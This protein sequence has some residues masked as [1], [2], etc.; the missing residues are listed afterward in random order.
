MI[1]TSLAAL[2][3]GQ[4]MTDEVRL[5]RYPDIHGDQYVFTYASDLW[6][7]QVDGGPARRLTSHPGLERNAKFSPDGQW[8]AFT[9]QYD[10][11]NDI[12]VIPTTGG[13][14]RRLTFEAQSENLRGWTPDGKK[15]AYTSIDGNHTNRMQRLWFVDFEGGMPERT[16]VQEAADLTFNADGSKMA[17]TRVA[18]HQYNW[19]RYRGGTQG[20]I[21]FW[22]FQAKSYTEIPTG[23]EQSYFPMW[24]GDT[25]YYISDRAQG[26]LNLWAY[27]TGPRRQRQLTRFTEGDIR[28]PATDGKKVIFERNLRLH[29]YD[30]ASGAIAT[31]EP[32]VT[33]D[34][35]GMRPRY[36][37][38]ANAVDS[39]ALSPSGARVVAEARGELF[40]VPATRGTT[41]NLTE[42]PGARERLAEW[43][44]DG[45]FV[46]YLSDASGEYKITR[47][48]Q[49]GGDA[50]VV[51]TPAEHRIAGF[52]LPLKGDKIAYNTN[53]FGLYVLDR[54]TGQSSLVHQDA[55]GMASYEW[56]PDGKWI[57]YMATQ[58]NLMSRV[59]LYDV[60]NKRS[61]AV[62]DGFYS[63]NSVSFDQSGKYLYLISSRTFGAT[64]SPMEGVTLLQQNMQRLYVITLDKSLGDPLLE[65]EDE[66]PVKT[67]GGEQGGPQGGGQQGSGD[68]KID[69]E[70]IG[71]RI[72]PLPLPAGNYP[73]VIGVNNGALYWANGTLSLF[74]MNTKRP[75]PVMAGVS[76]LSTNPARTKM[77]YSAGALQGIA[78]I[79]PGLEAGVGRVSFN[80]MGM[81][82]DPAAEFRQMYWD[83]WRFQRDHFYDPGMMGV[84][85]K[86]VG[87][88]WA[89]LL[90]NVGD[91]SDLDYMFG[92]LIGELGT[93]H[94]YVSPGPTGADPMAPPAGYLG[95]DYATVGNAVTFKKIYR[96]EEQ[97]PSVRGPL[98]RLG[99]EVNDGEYL[100]AIDG[101]PVTAKTGVSPHLIG[102]AN[103][104]VTL[105]VNSRN[106][107]VGAREVVVVPAT[108][109][110]N[111]RYQ[112]WVDERRA[113]VDKL[114]GGKVGYIHVP[115]TSVPGI[116]GF[117]KGF[118][119]QM[120]KEAWLVDERYNGGGSIPTFFIEAL[121]REF[122]NMIR[123]RHGEDVGLPVA[124]N[125]PKA[126]L[127][128][129]HAGSG[130]DLFPYLFKKAGL[131]PLIGT[132][133]WGG[134]VGISGGLQ[135]VA[136]GSVTSP[137]FGIYDPQTGQWIAENTGVDPDIEIDDDPA[138]AATGKDVQ[139][140]RGVRY[141]MEQL[142][143]GRTGIKSPATFP[144]L[145]G[146]R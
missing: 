125:G 101:K 83:V 93:G 11:G 114:S 109:E 18:S 82:T 146:G 47:K 64:G 51:A 90:G 21:A 72:V 88:K 66:E 53:E 56:S 127:I 79:R 27:E 105:T 68:I 145:D 87:D 38:L 122:T 12:Y 41:R 103:K 117:V 124:L 77:I 2:A 9:G 110:V 128:N 133:T 45:Q 74:S 134:L 39:V 137:A 119:S 115:D 81:T 70:G 44:A 37:N 80:D 34:N 94:A 75:A 132:R 120:D 69:L 63:D 123:P 130:G 100:L 10:G 1:V 20:R 24:V 57:V 85:W 4:S 135:L 138:S 99:V 8:I 95:A 48:P 42:T 43:S 23:R 140:E 136:G 131:G 16:D 52:S 111:L 102:K 89:G 33:G 98:G 108:T 14:P 86:A 26:T 31:L 60:E 129:E 106:S 58:P 28:W 73:F 91:R 61:H 144:T 32:R 22:D 107:T 141:L 113:L 30:L 121:Q 7:A 96:G 112:T 139:L 15:I 29:T 67:E 84:D 142:Q 46:Y 62:T 36:V 5:V 76:G 6:I 97:D 126:M 59:M 54:A 49:M 35:L 17:F 55:A 50:E 118:Y 143:R 116:V 25:V 78:D 92:L 19:R 13:E 65:P 71:Q 40:S 104:R 3:M